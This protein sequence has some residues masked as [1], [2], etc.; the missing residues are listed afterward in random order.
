MSAAP[1]PVPFET[2]FAH[3]EWVR[4][5]A[6]SLVLDGP[7]ADDIE[8][9]TWLAAL[10]RPPQRQASVRAWLGRV[11]RNLAWDSARARRRRETHELRAARPDALRSPDEVVAEAD[12]HARLVAAV[13]ALSEPYRTTVLLRWFED[14]PPATIADQVRRQRVIAVRNRFDRHVVHS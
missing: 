3:R 2:L 13:N 5:L 7:S 8:Q 11:V 1:P 6:R 4:R 9:Q 14:L 12:V 10:R